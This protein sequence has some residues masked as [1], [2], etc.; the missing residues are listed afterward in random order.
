MEGGYDYIIERGLTNILPRSRTYLIN[1]GIDLEAF[2]YNKNEDYAC[3]CR[4]FKDS[5]QAS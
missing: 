3:Y 4:A 2:N 5:R 1:N